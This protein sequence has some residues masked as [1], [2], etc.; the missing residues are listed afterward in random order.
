MKNANDQHFFI[1]WGLR[2]S[3]GLDKGLYGNLLL[4]FLLSYQIY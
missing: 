3:G 2:Q 1:L 4:A